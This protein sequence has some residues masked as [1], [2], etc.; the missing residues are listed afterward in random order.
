MDIKTALCRSTLFV[1]L[2]FK[3]LPSLF[4]YGLDTFVIVVAVYF[5]AG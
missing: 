4:K 3:P 2:D 5:Q 1:N